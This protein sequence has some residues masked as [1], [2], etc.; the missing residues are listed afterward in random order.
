MSKVS[1]P[2]QS[3]F[4]AG[5]ISNCLDAWKLYTRDPWV[6][7]NVFEVE[8]PLDFWPTQH[9]VP[10]PYR[11]NPQDWPAIRTELDQMLFTGVVQDSVHEP[12][13]S[14]PIFS[15]DQNRMGE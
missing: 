14:F 3:E 13:N 7:D 12:G 15:P 6:L 10:R 5:N 2:P 4:V 8:V 1:V 11:L 9:V